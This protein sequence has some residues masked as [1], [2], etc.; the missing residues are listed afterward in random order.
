[1]MLI[2]SLKGCT[3]IPQVVGVSSFICDSDY[4]LLLIVI[5]GCQFG[6]HNVHEDANAN[7]GGPQDT[8]EVQATEQPAEEAVAGD[9]QPQ[10]PVLPQHHHYPH[11]HH[12]QGPPQAGIRSGVNYQQGSG[13]P[14]RG[15]GMPG[16]YQGMGG[17]N[18][19]RGYVNGGRG[20]RGRGGMFPNGGRG[21]HFYDQPGGFHARPNHYGGRGG[22]GDRGGMMYN[23]HGNGAA[24][25]PPPIVTNST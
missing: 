17:R 5:S 20:G 23:G 4:G 11:S 2:V 6:S 18:G 14:V 24:P 19:G 9:E 3:D 21:G 12:A 25:S 15:R 7:A 10:P 13:G 22:R 16:G 8:E 1:M